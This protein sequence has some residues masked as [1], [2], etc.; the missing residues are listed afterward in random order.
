MPSLEFPGGSA[1]FE[2]VAR[3]FRQ[4]EG[5]LPK[6]LYQALEKSSKPLIRDGKRSAL[7]NLPRRGGLNRVIANARMSTTRRASGIRIKAKGIAQLARTDAGSVRHPV[8]GR[9]AWVDQSIPKARDWFEKPMRAGAPRVRRELTKA[10][11]KVAR[12]IA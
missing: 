4:A 8:Y 1:Q 10:L 5:E 6:E 7:A 9:S 12:R 11:D 2:R 3:A